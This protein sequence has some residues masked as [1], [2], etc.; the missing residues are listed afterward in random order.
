MTLKSRLQQI[1]AA[2]GQTEGC[3]P[4]T[5]ICRAMVGSDRQPSAWLFRGIGKSPDECGMNKAAAVEK[6]IAR[7]GKPV[8]AFTVSQLENWAAIHEQ[9]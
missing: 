2:S 5:A 6:F 4:V 8:S 7:S 3:Q 9:A 1:E